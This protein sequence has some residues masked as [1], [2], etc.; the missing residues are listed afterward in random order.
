MVRAGFDVN[1]FFKQVDFD[2]ASN[3]DGLIVSGLCSSGMGHAL[4]GPRECRYS[5][6][7]VDA[8][9]WGLF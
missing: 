9:Q 1:S 6:E 4:Q 8:S 2:K 3:E 5:T 7:Y